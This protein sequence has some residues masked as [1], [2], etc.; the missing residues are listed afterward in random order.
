MGG[1]RARRGACRAVL[2][3]CCKVVQQVSSPKCAC[4]VLPCISHWLPSCPSGPASTGA[5]LSRSPW[6]R[7]PARQLSVAQLS[8]PVVSGRLHCIVRM[9]STSSSPSG[10]RR[11]SSPPNTNRRLPT[12]TPCRGQPARG[13]A[14]SALPFLAPASWCKPHAALQVK[15]A[16]LLPCILLLACHAPN[17]SQCTHRV[18]AAWLRQILP[19]CRAALNCRPGARLGVQQ[20]HRHLWQRILRLLLGWEGS[21][22]PI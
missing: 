15:Q 7:P 9:S 17:A 8:A 4:C 18:A 10:R 14:G 2:F 22:E 20:A 3:F 5:Q 16:V 19:L 21:S 12:I 1:A 13:A 6:T 11:T